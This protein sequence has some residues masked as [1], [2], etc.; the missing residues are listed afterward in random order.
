MGALVGALCHALSPSVLCEEERGG[1]PGPGPLVARVGLLLRAGEALSGGQCW[2]LC[3]CEGTQVA[4]ACGL[5]EE[6]CSLAERPVFPPRRVLCE[7]WPH[8]AHHFRCCQ[9]HRLCRNPCAVEWG[10]VYR[11]LVISFSLEFR[12][13]GGCGSG[14]RSWSIFVYLEP[15]ANPSLC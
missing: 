7:V 14:F 1:H 8:R 13:R 11:N 9:R 6:G 3:L 4:Q 5:E 12:G 15:N 2:G 10:H